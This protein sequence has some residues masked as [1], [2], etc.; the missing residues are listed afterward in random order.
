MVMI[1]RRGRERRMGRAFQ[2]MYR[3][4]VSATIHFAEAPSLLLLR[5]YRRAPSPGADLR[6]FG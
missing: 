4:S 1:L 6:R 5:P 3:S 2:P